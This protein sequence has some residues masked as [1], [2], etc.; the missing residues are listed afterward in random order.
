MFNEKMRAEILFVTNIAGFGLIK[1]SCLFHYADKTLKNVFT[2]LMM[3][4]MY[5]IMTIENKVYLYCLI[6]TISEF[7]QFL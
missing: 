4:S 7:L 1:W 6:N 5:S 2:S 3:V